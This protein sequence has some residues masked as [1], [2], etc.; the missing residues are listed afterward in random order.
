MHYQCDTNNSAPQW[1]CMDFLES[2]VGLSCLASLALYKWP[3]I[4]VYMGLGYARVDMNETDKAASV[5]TWLMLTNACF[6][7]CWRN[8]TQEKSYPREIV[9]K[10][11]G[12]DF[13]G[14]IVPW[15]RFL[16]RYRTQGTI[17]P[18]ISYPK[19]EI[20]TRYFFFLYIYTFNIRFAVL[21]LLG[22]GGG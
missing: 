3:G 6:F 11:N 22:G 5:S 15:V 17:S 16:Q 9:P 7:D 13:S 8:R 4:W 14:E 12:Y 20:L 1:T 10:L 19:N 21:K 18:E 2:E